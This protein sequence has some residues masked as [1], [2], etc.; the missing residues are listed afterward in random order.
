MCTIVQL[1]RCNFRNKW[2]FVV[3]FLCQNNTTHTL[4][5]ANE[6]SSKLGS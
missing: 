1:V 5:Y 3:K 4:K 6:G 2:N